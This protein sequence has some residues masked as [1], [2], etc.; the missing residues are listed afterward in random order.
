[1][2]PIRNKKVSLS[3]SKCGLSNGPGFAT[4]PKPSVSLMTINEKLY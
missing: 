3:T 4:Y 2:I 1:M